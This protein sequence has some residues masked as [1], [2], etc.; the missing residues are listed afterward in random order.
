MKL[1][2]FLAVLMA[3]IILDV[4][5]ALPAIQSRAEDFPAGQTDKY[6]GGC[7]GQETVGRC[8]DKEQPVILPTAPTPLAVP[9][10]PAPAAAPPAK[11]AC[12]K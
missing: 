6:D 4:G 1:K 3:L 8:A 2:L 5:F 12:T 10:I 11:E 7:T 9:E